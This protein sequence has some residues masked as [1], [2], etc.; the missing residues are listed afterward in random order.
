[1]FGKVLLVAV[2]ALVLW[3]VVARA[4]EGAGRER[5]YVVQPHDTLWSIAVRTYGGDPRAAIWKIEHR[6]HLTGPRSCR[7]ERLR[8]PG[9]KFRL[10]GAA[11]PG[12]GH[13]RRGGQVDAALREKQPR[14]FPFRSR[15]RAREGGRRPP[16][17]GRT[18]PRSLDHRRSDR[19]SAR[20]AGSPRRR[21]A[22][23]DDPGI[24]AEFARGSRRRLPRHR[25]LGADRAP[26]ADRADGAP[27][28]RPAADRLRRGDTA[29]AHAL[30]H[31]PGRAAGGLPHALPR[32]PLPRPAGDAED[33]RA[34][35]PRAADHDLRAARACRPLRHRCAASSGSSRTRTSSS[36]SSRATSSTAATTA[37]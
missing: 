35:R 12:S 24:R 4:S 26:L 28:R 20:D 18:P 37:S 22:P 33:V 8:V 23:G 2:A 34:P 30:E 19:R 36:S 5:V 9:R 29:P 6:N 17:S 7:G 13:G 16:R 3:G 1:M 25:R 21:P 10:L 14:R 32:R 11:A 27:R 15:C 31:R